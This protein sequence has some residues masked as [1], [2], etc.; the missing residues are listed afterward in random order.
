MRLL[1]SVNHAERAVLV[2]GIIVGVV[3]A[4]GAT[5]LVAPDVE[6]WVWTP[7]DWWCR[8][9]PWFALGMVCAVGPAV[10]TLAA[11]LVDARAR[12][13][14]M[15]VAVG[16]AALGLAVGHRL[17]VWADWVCDAELP[18]EIG[19]IVAYAAVHTGAV[20]AAVLGGAWLYDTGMR[21]RQKWA[22]RRTG[23]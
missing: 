21:M 8:A 12:Q 10:G 7:N 22:C 3:A 9:F 4:H 16:A 18:C 13:V 15:W 14:P 17:A 5:A 1:K 20:A 6:C 23:G 2:V 11:R 19:T